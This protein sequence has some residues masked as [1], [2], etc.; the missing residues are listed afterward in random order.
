VK[1]YDS[2]ELPEKVVFKSDGTTRAKDDY[3]M[4]IVE[5]VLTPPGYGRVKVAK[6]TG[7]ITSEITK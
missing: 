7:F 4:H 2:W 5:D 1:D 6:L 3:E